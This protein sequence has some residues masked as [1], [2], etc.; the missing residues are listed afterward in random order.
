MKVQPKGTATIVKRGRKATPDANTELAIRLL[1][2]TTEEIPLTHIVVKQND[3]IAKAKYASRIRTIATRLG[4]PVSISWT[5]G[6]KSSP[7]VSKANR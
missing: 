6:A 7:V 3:K 5:D 1:R 4:K 2:K